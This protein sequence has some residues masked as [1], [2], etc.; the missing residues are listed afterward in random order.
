MIVGI[1]AS[2]YSATWGVRSSSSMFDAL[3]C[4]FVMQFLHLGYADIS[5]LSVLTS[6]HVNCKVLLR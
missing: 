6:S 3:Y 1:F 5:L 2:N 4:T